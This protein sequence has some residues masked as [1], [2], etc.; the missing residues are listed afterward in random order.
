[1]NALFP[2]SSAAK[3]SRRLSFEFP[4]DLSFKSQ[5]RIIPWLLTVFAFVL[6]AG[7]ETVTTMA[8]TQTPEKPAATPAATPT[9]AGQ[10]PESTP[11]P[12]TGTIKGR[13]VAGDGQ[14]L[15]NANV[16]AQALTSTPTAKPTRVDSEGR[17]VFDD[18]P[19]AAYIIV[20]T[21]PGYID[22]S[23]SLGDASQW[24]RH[25]IG[26]NVRVTMIRGGVITGLVT[27]AKGSR[28][29]VFPSALHCRAP[30]FQS[31]TFSPAEAYP[32]QMTA[33]S[34]EST[35]YCRVNTQSMRA[36]MDSLGRSLRAGLISMFPLTIHHLHATRLSRYRL[37]AVTRRAASTSSTRG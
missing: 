20:G 16:M 33:V 34:I 7:G 2:P 26:S 11:T 6:F 23:M 18:L 37:E 28:S 15:T 17:F 10:K 32:K 5:R 13:L 36:A 14:P 25:L 1:M 12:T 19:A 30:R 35:A 9:T 8:Q 4:L 21:A 24:P 3:I 22:Q 27:N 29:S 31:P